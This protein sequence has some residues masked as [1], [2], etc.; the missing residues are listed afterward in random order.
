[1]V[2]RPSARTSCSLSHFIAKQQLTLQKTLHL[3][4]NSNSATG[5]TCGILVQSYETLHGAATIHKTS[6]MTLV[7]LTQEI[8]KAGKIYLF[9]IC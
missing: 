4:D 6:E 5:A 1:M 2:S 9:K 8:P 7:I 3:C